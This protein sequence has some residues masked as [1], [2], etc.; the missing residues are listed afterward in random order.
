MAPLPIFVPGGSFAS[1]WRT[2][3]KNPEMTVREWS[4]AKTKKKTELEEGWGVARLSGVLS[5]HV[6]S[7]TSIPRAAYSVAYTLVY[8]CLGKG[9]EAGGSEVQ[10]HL[11][12]HGE[13]KAKEPGVNEKKRTECSAEG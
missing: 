1:A 9:L 5:L 3:Q 13:F 4:P 10:G 6:Q 11:Q 7:R 12:Q 2:E 8:P